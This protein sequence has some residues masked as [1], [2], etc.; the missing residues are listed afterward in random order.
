MLR[1]ELN[2]NAPVLTGKN[3]T[4]TY[5]QRLTVLKVVFME[6]LEFTFGNAQG[7]SDFALPRFADTWAGATVADDSIKGCRAFNF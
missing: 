2:T 6:A 5:L 7:M 3:D 1:Y 4:A